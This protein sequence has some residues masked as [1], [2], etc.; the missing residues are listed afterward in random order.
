MSRLGWTVVGVVVW[1]MVPFAPPGAL[2]AVVRIEIDRREPFAAGHAFGRSGPYEKLSGRLY[3]EVD[4]Q[5]SD[6][7][8]AGTHSHGVWRSEDG[9]NFWT[10]VG[11]GIPDQVP[12]IDLAYDPGDPT[13]V[14]AGTIEA[15]I[16]KSTNGGENLISGGSM[17]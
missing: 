14:F 16:Y 11:T 12:V 8:L 6:T 4:P 15:G 2:G 5:N 10:K 7:I 17:V 1:W 13:V 3:L 9:G